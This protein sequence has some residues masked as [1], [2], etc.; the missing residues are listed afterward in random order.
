MRYMYIYIYVY[1]RKR[2]S[3]Y[4][5][6]NEVEYIHHIKYTCLYINNKNI[7]YINIP[8]TTI[9]PIRNRVSYILY[10]CELLM[11]CT[12]VHLKPPTPL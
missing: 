2:F 1:S 11:V 8:G 10:E 9:H 7:V 6:C 3:K 5:Q 12:I 4:I